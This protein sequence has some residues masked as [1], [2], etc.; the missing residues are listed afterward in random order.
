MLD[1]LVDVLYF[2]CDA[3]RTD[4]M[5]RYILLTKI[6]ICLETQRCCFHRSF[7]DCSPRNLCSLLCV[8]PLSTLTLCDAKV[9]LV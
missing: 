2:A 8:S 1:C 5:D 9:W 4:A 6:R 7:A 3:L